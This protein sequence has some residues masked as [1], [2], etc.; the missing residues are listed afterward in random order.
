LA[1]FAGIQRPS[2][3]VKRR[4]RVGLSGLHE[5]ERAAGHHASMR[6]QRLDALQTQYVAETF[7]GTI[8]ENAGDI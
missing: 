7:A 5:I 6:N 2:D 8:D 4:D 3:H 1:K